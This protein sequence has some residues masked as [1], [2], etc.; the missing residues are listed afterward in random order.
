LTPSTEKLGKPLDL[1][2]AQAFLMNPCKL[3]QLNIGDKTSHI[4]PRFLYKRMRRLD[5]AGNYSQTF[6]ESSTDG[7]ATDETREATEILLCGACEQLIGRRESNAARFLDRPPPPKFCSD[8]FRQYA[9]F[10]YTSIKLFFLSYLWRASV[11]NELD[12]GFVLF[13]L[14]LNGADFKEVVST[15]D[16]GKKGWGFVLH[17]YF[18]IVLAEDAEQFSAV[19]MRKNGPYRSFDRELKDLWMFKAHV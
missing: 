12:Y 19:L 5:D 17:R 4:I 10:D 6:L 1:R 16:I 14:K 11:S 13:N 8:P 18:V 9:R 3:C 7:T 15:P 2:S